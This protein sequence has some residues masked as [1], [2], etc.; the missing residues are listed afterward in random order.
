MNIIGQAVFFF[1]LPMMLVVFLVLPPRR[2]VVATAVG[3]WLFLPQ[4]S[5]P[6]PGLPNYTKVSALTVGLL[7]A[8]ILFAP[9]KLTRLR[10]RWYDLP[11]AIWCVTPFASVLSNDLGLYSAMSSLVSQIVLWGLPYL[12]GRAYFG[13]DEGLREFAMGIVAGGLIYIPLCLWEIR[14]S[15]LLHRHAFGF[16]QRAGPMALGAIRWGGY[17]PLVFMASGLEVG[18]YMA[19][20]TVVA[21]AL[22]TSGAAR[23]VLNLP[24]GWVFG[25]LLATTVLCKSTGAIVLMLLGLGILWIS[26]RTGSRIPLWTLVVVAPL[27][28]TLRI[29]QVLDTDSIVRTLSDLFGQDRAGSFAFRVDNENELMVKALQRPW[30]GWGGFGRSFVTND[31]G[32]SVTIIDSLW[33]SVLGNQGFIGLVAITA[34]QILPVFLW[35]RKGAKRPWCQPVAASGAALAVALG[36]YSI[37]NLLN[38]MVSPIYALIAGGLMGWRGPVAIESWRELASRGRAL[39]QLGRPVEAAS[40][41][42]Q[43]LKSLAPLEDGPG[44][45]QILAD[46]HNDLAWILCIDPTSKA[47]DP[48]AAALHTKA[49]LEANPEHAAAWNTRGL[50]L[51]RRGDLAGAIHAFERSIERAGGTG[52]DHFP[53][54]M[55]HEQMG[56][57]VQ[58]RQCLDDAVAWTQVNNPNHPELLR[59]W[60]EAARLVVAEPR[61]D[62]DSPTHV[63]PR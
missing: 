9:A 26:K 21:Y 59:L 43:A 28:L 4:A 51:C 17:R 63:S 37:D 40:A 14:M 58:A 6:L 23:K 16:T 36:L 44:I 20:T 33:I 62:S 48:E 49:A 42:R 2:A 10:F 7:L 57:H 3:F 46:I 25:G 39:K 54:A 32:Q 30:L 47:Y 55:T 52:F 34:V 61:T 35:L 31:R 60:N 1:A 41:W 29:S 12:I 11:M 13:D 5:L 45:R 24:L 22:W 15:P 53:M 27:F 50:A 19:A 8:T 56:N 18:L 38:A